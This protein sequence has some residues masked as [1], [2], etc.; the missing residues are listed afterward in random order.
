MGLAPTWWAYILGGALLVGVCLLVELTLRQTIPLYKPSFPWAGCVFGLEWHLVWAAFSGMETILYIFLVLGV[1]RLLLTGSRNYLAAGLLAGVSIWVRPD[2]ITLLGPLALGICLDQSSLSGRIRG[3]AGLALGFGVLFLPY[4]VFNLAVSGA[5]L[6]NTFYAKQAE[7]AA[8]QSSSITNRLLLLS[9]Q[10]FLGT[11]LVL[12]P[13]FIIKL[14]KA[15]RTC[16]RGVLLAA[17]WLVGYCVLYVTRLPVYQHGRYTMPA[18]AIFLLIGFAGFLENLLPVQRPAPGALRSVSMASLVTVLVLAFI[19]GGRVYA[20]DVAYIETEMV[21]TSRWVAQNVPAGAK[22][23]AHDI[24]AL[25]YFDRHQIIDLAGL[26]S[27]EIVP[28]INNDQA[29]SNYMRAQGVSY[30]VAFQGWKPALKRG[31]EQIY[32]AGTK[33]G[34]QAGLGA[35]AVYRISQP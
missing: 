14:V 28:I 29:I 3:L 27:P 30:L 34:D 6:P 10:F 13:G 4:L 23:A 2:G 1:M 16:E 26:I 22:V 21:D 18:L 11:S 9:L 33:A 35:M 15:T 8:W 20:Q 32:L 17:T 19:Y 31:A 25:G 24:G 12:I 5:P 7:Y